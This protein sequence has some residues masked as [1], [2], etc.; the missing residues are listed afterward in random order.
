MLLIQVFN[1]GLFNSRTQ[2][3]N[4]A[5]YWGAEMVGALVSAAPDLVCLHIRAARYLVRL[6][7]SGALSSLLQDVCVFGVMPHPT[8]GK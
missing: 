3:W 1:A 2:G 7:M 4:T 8:T 6:H 5:W